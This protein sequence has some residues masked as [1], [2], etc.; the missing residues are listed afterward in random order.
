[1]ELAKPHLDIGL[2]TN[3]ID[4]QCEFWSTTIGLRLDHVLELDNGWAQHRFDAHNSV[5]KI[6]H[7]TRPLATMPRS[8]YTGLAIAS[9]AE[10]TWSG[11]HPSG[12]TV[13]LVA[14]GTQG[15]VGI[16]ITVSTPEPARM[17]DFYL[18]AMQFEEVDQMTARCGDSLLFVEQ[19]P[20]GKPSDDFKGSAFRYLT[21]QIFDADE[22]CREIVDRGGDLG[23]APVSYKDIARYGFV[24]DPDGNWIEMSARTSLTGIKPTT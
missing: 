1:M 16:G 12:D 22:A 8:G 9:A 20:G 3:D 19:G 15:I 21:V 7:V 18:H 4:E 11:K 5:I 10:H 17:M 6:N 23:Q 13:Q 14:P 24:C 2:F